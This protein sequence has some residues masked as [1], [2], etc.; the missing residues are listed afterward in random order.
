MY[1]E[2][3]KLYFIVLCS[4]KYYVCGKYLKNVSPRETL[5]KRTQTKN[6]FW[7]F[8]APFI[9][10]Y[11]EFDPTLKYIDVLCSFQTRR[12]YGQ[13]FSRGGNISLYIS[14]ISS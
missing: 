7:L 14:G 5:Q 3:K 8:N 1:D 11:T 10:L 4:T 2:L 12:D 6:L 9:I 13:D